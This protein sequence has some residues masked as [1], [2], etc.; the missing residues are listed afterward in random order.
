MSNRS[1]LF[2]AATV[3]APVIISCKGGDSPSRIDNAA[4]AKPPAT[5]VASTT[6]SAVPPPPP[7]PHAAAEL[8]PELFKKLWPE[9]TGKDLAGTVP[10]GPFAAL[11]DVCKARKKSGDDCK[12]EEQDVESGPFAKVASIRVMEA[13]DNNDN[14]GTTTEY[15][16]VKAAAGWYVMPFTNL[17]LLNESGFNV[18]ARPGSDAAVVEYHRSEGNRHSY[19]EENGIVACK[20]VRGAVSCTPRIPLQ[21]RNWSDPNVD[22]QLAC[23]ASYADGALTLDAMP[24]PAESDSGWTA[25]AA[26]QC[27]TLPYAGKQP[28]AF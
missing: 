7:P 13:P 12:V 14:G 9:A 18:T 26:E 19:D 11:D 3:I 24:K 21:K 17:T 6:G 8:P 4:A 23:V 2:I 22:V 16:A 5:A 25:K 1:V 15:A 27:K 10:L 28:I 20:P